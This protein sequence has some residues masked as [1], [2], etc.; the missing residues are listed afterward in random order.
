MEIIIIKQILFTFS[1]LL[2]WTTGLIYGNDVTQTSILWEEQ[3]KEATMSC[4]HTKGDT[5]RYMYWYRQ[6]PGETMKLIVFTTTTT[7][8]HDFG[9]FSEEKFSA[10]KTKPESGT[11]TVKKLESQDNGLYFC[12][13]IN[14][15][16]V[17]Q[18]PLPWGDEGQSATLNCRHE[19]GSLY[20]QMYW[21]RQLP[22]ETMKQVVF[23][24]I[25]TQNHDFEPD[26]RDDR[27]SATK[28]KP[29]SGTF[30]LKKLRPED[31]GLYFCAVSEHS[32]TDALD[33]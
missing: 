26:F 20:Y 14:G 22:G 17:T 19:K 4:S 9:E 8:K 32:D 25:T 10:T 18:T 15:D 6:L 33:S 24:S 31:N 2:L 23:T 21:Y 30:T 12:A 11:F 3:G 28:A 29:E 7:Q 27:F 1:I 13:V 5:Y 16:D